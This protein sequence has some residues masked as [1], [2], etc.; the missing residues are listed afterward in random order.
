MKKLFIITGEFSADVHAAGVVK[1][2]KTK[3]PDLQIEAVGGTNLAMCGVKLFAN[4]KKMEAAGFNAKILKEHLDL[5]KNLLNYL[6]KE[7]KPDVVLLL[8]Y[9]GF[10]L[11]MA[12]FIKLEM[13]KTKILYFIPP[14]IWASR[15]WRIKA[16][17]KYIDKVL[18]IFPFEEE[19]YK[20]NNIPSEFVGHPLVAELPR[21]FAKEI[22][23]LEQGL[24]PAKK[25]ISVFPGSR[26]FEI[27]MLMPTLMKSVELL[28]KKFPEVQFA[29]CQSPSI[30]DTLLRNYKIPSYV[31]I[32]K[33]NNYD[34]LAMSDAL[35][36]ASG[37]VALEA[38]LYKTPMVVCY[39]AP[40][41]LYTIYLMV[42]CIKQVSLPNI[43][44]RKEV[45]PELIQAKCKPKIIAEH[46]SKIIGDT[47]ER[48][49]MIYELSKL[50][51]KLSE[52]NALE[53]VADNVTEFL[54][55]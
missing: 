28:H 26:D 50:S 44:L 16:V 30:K 34:L 14:Q 21:M 2:L 19:L 42:R 54:K 46:V 51:E 36:L 12:K 11:N 38:A 6:K 20:G 52:K 45:V 22:F 27:L 24:E 9:G 5:G 33:G 35:I 15:K 55:N 3:M 13:P 31:K 48:S 43:I 41:L 1:I 40:W 17:K 7:Y 37:T 49:Q 8:D 25:L 4:H 39:R 23:F 10:N 47:P 29:L 32:I 18:Y 53:R